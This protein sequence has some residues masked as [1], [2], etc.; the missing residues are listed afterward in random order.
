M[1]FTYTIRH[2][3]QFFDFLVVV[4]NLRAVL[5]LTF[6]LKVSTLWPRLIKHWCEMETN[7]ASYGPVPNLKRRLTILPFL[8]LILGTG[9]HVLFVCGGIRRALSKAS[10]SESYVEKYFTLVYNEFFTLFGYAHWKAIIVEFLALIATYQW[11]F[12]NLLI[13]LLSTALAERFRQ[14]RQTINCRKIL[15]ESQWRIIRKQYNNLI[16]LCNFLNEVLSNIVVLSFLSNVYF[17]S[18]SILQCLSSSQTGYGAMYFYYGLLFTAFHFVL[19]CWYASEVYEESSASIS[20]LAIIP[21]KYLSHEID[22][23]LQQMTPRQT[24]ISGGGFFDVKRTSILSIVST[25]VT[26]ELIFMEFNTK[27]QS[28]V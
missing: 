28:N 20:E 23:L 2:G 8:Y 26:I 3:G 24:A 11:Q 9:E 5:N 27:A 14:I 7:M 1:M 22:R 10:P 21:T 6:L 15:S 25:L 17:L 13:T 19:L 18:I 16:I 4:W 12:S